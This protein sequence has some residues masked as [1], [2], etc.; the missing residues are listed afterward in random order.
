MGLLKV[1]FAAAV[2]VYPLAVF[3]FLVVF[4][5]PLRAIALFMGVL[6][7]TYFLSVSAKKKR[8]VSGSPALYGRF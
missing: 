3:C 4:K 7:L 8:G 1:F 2:L 6:A 5:L